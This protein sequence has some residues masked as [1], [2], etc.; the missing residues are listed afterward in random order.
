VLFSLFVQVEELD[1]DLPLAPDENI[2]TGEDSTL[3]DGDSETAD[4]PIATW[5][6]CRNCQKVVT[7]LVYIS[8]ST[9]KFSFGKVSRIRSV[10]LDSRTRLTD[11]SLVFGIVL[12]QSRFDHEFGMF[13]L[14]PIEYSS[15]FW[16]R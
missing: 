14:S 6:Y 9:W 12:L 4:R 15:L 2:E 11:Q 13:L 8:E 10:L 5:T 7:P 16:L 3:D 1:D